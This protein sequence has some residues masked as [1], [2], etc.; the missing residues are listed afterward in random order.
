[1]SVDSDRLAEIEAMRL[2][3]GAHDSFAGGAGVME[4]VAYI[5]GEP[6]SDHPQCASPVLG[7]LLR[8]WNDGLDNEARQRLKPYVVRLVG[9]AGNEHD[10]SRRREVL[11]E[12]VL[13][14]L[15]PK[16]LETAGMHAE[17][18]RVRVDGREALAGVRDRAWESRMAAR[19]RAEAQVR[20]YIESTSASEH[21]APAATVYEAAA[22]AAAA[23]VAEAACAAAA[24]EPADADDLL[25]NAAAFLDAAGAAAACLDEETDALVAYAADADSATAAGYA[26]VEA[27]WSAMVGQLQESAFDL[28]D[29]LIDVSQNLT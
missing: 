19:A 24:A 2:G 17:A 8:A 29:R 23:Y 26:Y 25:A 12:W 13:G 22:F 4:C 18:E 21:A 3:K 27:A 14:T 20:D 10:E 11:W 1:M 7:A 5:A 9:T 6:I 16:W 28:L 15:V